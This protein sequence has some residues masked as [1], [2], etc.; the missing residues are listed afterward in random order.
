MT[1]HQ[2]NRRIKKFIKAVTKPAP[3][4]VRVTKPRPKQPMGVIFPL[5]QLKLTPK[6]PDALVEMG[7]E[8]GQAILAHPEKYMT[9]VMGVETMV[10]DDASY[11]ALFY[12][13]AGKTRQQMWEQDH[14]VA[15][16]FVHQFTVISQTLLQDARNAEKGWRS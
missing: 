16:I 8:I 14:I 10:V 3:K 1:Y 5:E 7:R 12:L 4:P 11:E 2:L 6:S 15:A 13:F 9:Q